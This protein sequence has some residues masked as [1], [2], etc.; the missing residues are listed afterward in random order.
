MHEKEVVPISRLCANCGNHNPSQTTLG[1]FHIGQSKKITSMRFL[2]GGSTISL[3]TR[4]AIAIISPRLH[5]LYPSTPIF[6][7]SEVSGEAICSL[8]CI[9][10]CEDDQMVRH[11]VQNMARER[12]DIVIPNYTATLGQMADQL[13]QVSRTLTANGNKPGAQALP[14]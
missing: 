14:C 8:H 6:R 2:V 13:A 1:N 3:I 12:A 9:R 7:R 4:H 5:Q 10:L 11:T